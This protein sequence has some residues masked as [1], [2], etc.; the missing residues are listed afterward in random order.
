MKFRGE[1]KMSLEEYVDFFSPEN[2]VDFTISHLNQIIHMHGFRKLHKAHKKIVGEAVDSLNLI[3]PFR[4]TLKQTGAVSSSPSSSSL[5][6]DEVIT[7]IE[8]LKWQECC[9]TSLQIINS[10]SSSTSSAPAPKRNQKSNKRKKATGT[11]TK[12]GDENG[13]TTVVSFPALPRKIRTK[14]TMKSITSLNEASAPLKPLSDNNSF[15][16][17]FTTIP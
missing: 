4:S 14:K 6:L 2:P 10:E 15:P 5:T 17:R 3:D 7:D 1:K 11:T 9:L 8:A 13:I 12:S 16:S